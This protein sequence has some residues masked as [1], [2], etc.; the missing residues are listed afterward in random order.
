MLA[1][2]GS[3]VDSNATVSDKIRALARAGYGRAEIARL[4]DKRYQHVRNVLVDDERR[5]GS[6]ASPIHVD[7]APAQGQFAEIGPAFLATPTGEANGIVWLEIAADG[8]LGLPEPLRSTLGVERGG[9]VMAQLAQDGTVTLRSVE[10]AVKQAQAIFS[11]YAKPG[12]SLV[13]ELIEDRRAEARRES[14]E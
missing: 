8:R 5:G 7:D 6:R 12:V 11:R 3:I 2:P 14:S 1:D 13:D 4:L 10:A 9:K